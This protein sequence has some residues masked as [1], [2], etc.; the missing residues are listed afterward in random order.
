MRTVVIVSV[1]LGWM[2]GAALAQNTSAPKSAGQAPSSNVQASADSQ[3]KARKGAKNREA[4]GR[5]DRKAAAEKRTEPQKDPSDVREALTSCLAMWE[6][7]T[8]MT[9]R[10]WARACRRVAERLR[11]I[12]AQ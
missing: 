12:T 8:H 11:G 3:A 6:P 9:R 1:S 2:A 4:K 5:T 10:E 7:A